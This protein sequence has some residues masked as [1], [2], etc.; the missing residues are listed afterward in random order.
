[1]TDC[2]HVVSFP[3]QSN[4]PKDVAVNTWHTTGTASAAGQGI[5]FATS[6]AAFYNS[7]PAGASA[8]LTSFYSSWING[9]GITMKTYDLSDPK[10]R[11][12]VV[13]APLSLTIPTTAPAPSE[14]ALCLSY[15]AAKVAGL[16]Q[17]RRR[18]RIYTGP[19]NTTAL[20]GSGGSVC[21][22]AAT[23]R[24]TLALA[25]KALQALNTASCSWAVYDGHG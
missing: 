25:G 16:S 6:L 18:G 4:I 19:F 22:P 15:Q 13:V 10:P 9:S 8:R 21:R 24:N 11:P 7:I 5:S 2:L 3:Y 23:L 1:M 17:A 14:I 12:P 20:S